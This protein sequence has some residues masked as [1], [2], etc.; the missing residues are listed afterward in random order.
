M[1]GWPG[2][3]FWDKG[4]P[5]SFILRTRVL[6]A[7]GIP[8]GSWPRCENERHTA[9]TTCPRLKVSTFDMNRPI[10]NTI[11]TSMEY[12][13]DPNGYSSHPVAPGLNGPFGRPRLQHS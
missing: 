9:Q 13:Q 7:A 5:S 10:E 6:N 11:G 12:G 3:S 2:F 1:P 8:R 4:T